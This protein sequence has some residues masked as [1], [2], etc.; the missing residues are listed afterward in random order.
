[1][2]IVFMGTPQFAVPSLAELINS[3]QVVG[4][5]TQPDRPK[6][7][8]NKLTM[9]PVKEE[10]LKHNIPVYQPERIKMEREYLDILADLKPDYIVVVAFGQILSKEVLDIPKYG[11]VNLHA[12][13]LPKYRGA[14]PINWCLIKGEEVSGNTTMLMDEGL[15][16]GAML[17]RDE[18]AITKDMTAGELHDELMLRGA[19]LLKDT[20]L[21][22]AA[23]NIVPIAQNSEES[24]YASMLD[25]QIA[26]ID[27]NKSAKDIHNLIRGLNP[28]PIAYTNYRGERLKIYKSTVIEGSYRG[29]PGKIHK[30]SENGLEVLTGEGLLSVG[31]IQ[32]PSGKILS[33]KDYLRGNKI[34]EGEI[35]K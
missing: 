28:W 33:V 23:G 30:V 16:T 17:L 6:G 11:C 13:L 4:V 19:K 5:F 34:L 24:C 21:E 1:M 2:R 26:Q 9:S 10:A 27:W 20:L 25:K 29:E 3:F 18:V 22:Y 15:D 7:R 12:S 14:A 35:L 32:F 8:G 31:E